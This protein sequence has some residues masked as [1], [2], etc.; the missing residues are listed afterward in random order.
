[1]RIFGLSCAFALALGHGAIAAGINQDG[2]LIN[3]YTGPELT[4][5]GAD[6]VLECEALANTAGGGTLAR[7]C[8][9]ACATTNHVASGSTP[10]SHMAGCISGG[11]KDVGCAAALATIAPRDP[12]GVTD[13]SPDEAYRT[14]F[15]EDGPCGHL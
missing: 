3:T 14:M 6:C 4:C 13:T 15:S 9:T 10:S 2:G 12:S 5:V 11:V 8:A 7:R 1:M